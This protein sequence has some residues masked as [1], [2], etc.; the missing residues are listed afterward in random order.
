MIRAVPAML[1]SRLRFAGDGGTISTRL[2]EAG[3]A[4]RLACPAHLLEDRRAFDPEFGNADF[5]HAG[6]ISTMRIQ[7]SKVTKEQLRHEDR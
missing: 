1:P 4:N 3:H 2:P 7:R 5:F 6:Y